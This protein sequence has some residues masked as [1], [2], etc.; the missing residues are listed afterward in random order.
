MNNKNQVTI[1]KSLIIKNSV[2]KNVYKLLVVM[3]TVAFATN[4]SAQLE[5]AYKL[6]PE[7]A[8]MGVG[9]GQG[10]ISWWSNSSA[11][12]ELRACFFD[13]LYVFN[14]DGS[15]ENVL[16]DETWLEVWQGVSEDGCGTPVAPHDGTGNYTFTY[17]DG[18]GT[19]TINGVGGY[20]GLAKVF[21]GGELASPG[22]APES[23]TYM[24]DVQDGGDVLVIDIEVGGGGWWRFKMIADDYTPPTG[25]LEGM[26]QMAPMAGAMGVGPGQGDISWWS[27]SDEDLST[28]ACFF[29][30]YYV[31]NPDASFNNILQDE[32]WVEAWQGGEDAC[33]TPVAP[34]DGTAVATWAYD[35]EAAIVTINGVGGFLGIPKAVNGT[36]LTSPDQAPESVSYF[37]SFEDDGNIMVLDIEAGVGVWWRFKMA[38][39]GP[40]GVSEIENTNFNTFP[41]PA[42][43]Y[44]SVDEEFQLLQI[45][46]T[47]GSQVFEVQKNQNQINVSDLSSGVYFIQMQTMEGQFKQSKFV[48][49]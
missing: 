25:E 27:N 13:D 1:Y 26:W 24:I 28:R 41:N 33:G 5:G 32:T 3:L 17:D 38:Y 31:F 18:A 2:M 15:F 48:K 34:H 43:D 16:Q 37:V 46:N 20:L 44:I 4:V 7:A 9:P 45:Y 39:M 11:D 23:I 47:N 49:K 35:A 19:V 6:A 22:D 42:M 14:T 29:D 30:D 12:V 21:N 10:D 8:A 36:E 40:V